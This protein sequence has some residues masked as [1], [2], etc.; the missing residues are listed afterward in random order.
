MKK[1]QI[2]ESPYIRCLLSE[3]R[4]SATEREKFR[5]ISDKLFDVLVEAAI[6]ESDTKAG[7]ART[8]V[9]VAVSHRVEKDFVVIS[10][11]RSG[12]AMIP[13]ALKILPHAR[14]GFAGV[15]RDE[16]TAKPS[17]YYWKMPPIKKNSVL[18]IID[19]MLATGGT[20][21]HV[22]KNLEGI[23]GERRLVCAVASPEGIDALHKAYPNV[24]VVTASVDEGLNNN[25]YIV[26]GLG[27]FGDR[28]FG[29][30]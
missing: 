13:S 1:V 4:E 27:D 18:L 15:V 5:M 21:L 19:P 6:E 16:V 20:V 30:E 29:T 26:P 11:L 7:T 3:L 9:G 25:K 8:P 28:Y 22:L 23:G 12:I 24:H 17:E 14:I 10:V 2:V